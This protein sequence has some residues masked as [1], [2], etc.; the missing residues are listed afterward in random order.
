MKTQFK[1]N[2]FDNTLILKYQE[3]IL[4]SRKEISKLIIGQ[5]DLI[6]FIFIALL[7]NGHVLL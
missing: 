7:S 6:D 2:N 5:K 3:L 4:Q 1:E